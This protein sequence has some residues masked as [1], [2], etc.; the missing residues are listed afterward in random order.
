MIIMNSS[1]SS[2]STTTTT[3]II[4]DTHLTACRKGN[5][6][7]SCPLTTDR[8]LSLVPDSGRRRLVGITNILFI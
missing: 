5:R 6:T 1:S 3:T 7:Q 4:Y 8:P 2:S